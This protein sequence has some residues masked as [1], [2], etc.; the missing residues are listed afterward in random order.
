VL[1][2]A[3]L[4]RHLRKAV[5]AARA[6]ESFDAI[7]AALQP[8][9]DAIPQQ[10]VAAE[11]AV[12]IV[13][14]DDFP[15][16]GRRLLA[17]AVLEEWWTRDKELLVQLGER[18][19]HLTDIDLLNRP[20]EEGLVPGIVEA[21]W[22]LS[23]R[24]TDDIDVLRTLG[25]TARLA[26]RAFDETAEAAL[27]R[28]TKVEP[29]HAPHWYNLG[30]FYKTRGR[31]AEGVIAN[32]RALSLD[33][34]FKSAVWNLGICATGD[35]QGELALE[36]WCHR[37]GHTLELDDN[38]AL[39][40]GDYHMCQ[41]RL[42]QRPLAERNADDDEPGQEETVWIKRLSPC[43]GVIRNA[44][45][46]AEDIGLDYGDMVLFDGAPIVMRQWGEETVPVFPHLTTLSTGDHH[47][48][49]FHATQPAA[50][51]V[52]NWMNDDRR[53]DNLFIEVLTENY[54]SLCECCWKDDKSDHADHQVDEHRIVD[55]K[56]CF[57]KTANAASIRDVID[58]LADETGVVFMVPELHRL[59]GDDARASV[60]ARRLGM[61]THSE[62]G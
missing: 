41:V 11:A 25:T 49:A 55:G 29:D 59:V 3:L 15:F 37:L 6:A 33:D 14:E 19:Q 60:D 46:Y 39:P 27:H 51:V 53:P 12:L 1:T 62:D 44:V 47:A 21:L 56:L 61:L 18:S 7:D 52:A 42:A 30:L 58:Q 35:G 24:F 45:I 23:E 9:Y 20:A 8:F 26:G 2:D 4:K 34:D 38:T 17:G 13:G 16:A 10:L 43:H 50:E 40:A 48:L 5:E 22:E 28:C 36:M 32:Q 54:V 31:F 57:P